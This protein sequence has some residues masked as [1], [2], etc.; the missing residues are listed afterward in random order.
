[1]PNIISSPEWTRWIWLL[2]L[3]L[4]TASLHPTS[5]DELSLLLARQSPASGP[6]PDQPPK[7][8]SRHFTPHNWPAEQTALIICDMWDSHHSLAATRRTGELAPRIDALAAR[9]REAGGLIIHAPSGCLD[10]YQDHP[11]RLR[12]QA[13]PPADR[14]PADIDTW[15]QAL[16]SEPQQPPVDASDGGAD[17]TPE[18]ANA[19]RSEL[20]AKGRNPDSPW[21]AQ[22]PGLT[23]VAD[24]DYLSDQGSE[25]ASILKH[26]AIEHVLMAGVHVNMCVLGRPFGLRRLNQL[27]IETA[28]VR[29]LTDSMYN[30]H[31][32]PMVSHFTGTD[33]IIDHIERFVCPTIES[34]QLLGGKPFRFADDHRPTLTMLLAED[35]YLSS[36][37]LPKLAEAY[38][39]HDFRTQW[40]LEEYDS[41]G[42]LAGVEQLDTSDVLL[43]SARRRQLPTS[44]LQQI[45]DWV[46]AGGAVVGIRTASHAFALRAGAAMAGRS[47]WPDFDQQVFGGNYTNHHGA[48]EP[49]RV[50]PTAIGHGHPLL[51]GLPE[52]GFSATGSLYRVSPIA[53]AATPLLTGHIAAAAAEPVAYYLRRADGGRSFYTSLGHP[54]ELAPHAPA[55]RLIIN[56]IYWAAGLPVPTQLQPTALAE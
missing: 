14:L 24:R 56:A 20:I 9:L 4:F 43:I 12:A 36:Q 50:L 17:D 3:G 15:C 49:V 41:P 46:A 18:M 25:I 1:M 51:T 28:L 53:P 7:L 34:S 22:H 39:G 33:R 30:P 8:F 13:I 16:A 47:L 42:M 5:A 48:S 37:T 23:I 31:R 11:S 27:G 6:G 54:D 10:R 32:W 52:S 38:L 44:Q 45:R 19:W 21:L 2:C 29:D 26:H 35:E 55:S 40:I